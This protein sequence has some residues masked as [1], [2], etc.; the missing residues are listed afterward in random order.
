MN[1]SDDAAVTAVSKRRKGS[2]IVNTF[3]KHVFSAPT[4]IL[5]SALVLSGCASPSVSTQAEGSSTEQTL[6]NREAS[7]LTNRVKVCL[8]NKTSHN[9]GYHIVGRH[10]RGENGYDSGTLGVGSFTGAQFAAVF[11]SS[12]I[13]LSP[14]RKS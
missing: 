3:I 13:G 12:Q 5:G 9:Q 10:N 1:L 2:S 7:W 4:T 11:A 6:E 14:E 8:H